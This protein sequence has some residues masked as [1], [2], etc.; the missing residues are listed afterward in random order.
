M[1]IASNVIEFR[2]NCLQLYRRFCSRSRVILQ[3]LRSRLSR[4]IEIRPRNA[5]SSEP[6]NRKRHSLAAVR[7]DLA[8]VSDRPLY[9]A[10]QPANRH[11]TFI[12]FQSHHLL[13]SSA[14]TSS[15]PLRRQRRLTA[16]PPPPWT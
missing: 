13:L 14:P 2:I 12:I 11:P 3:P 4:V 10:N 5:T 1:H 16:G 15:R 9:K 6:L 7:F 8:T